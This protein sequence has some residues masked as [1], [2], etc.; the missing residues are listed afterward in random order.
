[1]RMRRD[2]LPA[3]KEFYY[4]M[5]FIRFSDSLREKFRSEA[6]KGYEEDKELRM[7]DDVAREERQLRYPVAGQLTVE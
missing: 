4:R 5:S 2:L 7:A 3:L 6:V 1:M